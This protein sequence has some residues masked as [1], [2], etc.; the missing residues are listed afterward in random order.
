MIK[1]CTIDL[2]EEV[3]VPEAVHGL[4]SSVVVCP[5]GVM[6]NSAE[7]DGVVETSSNLGVISTESGAVSL[8]FMTRSLKNHARDNTVQRIRSCFEM[9]GAE[10]SAEGA[11]PGWTPSKD[12]K[13]LEITKSVYLGLMGKEAGVQVI[14][15]GLE[16]GLLGDIYPDWDMISFGPTITG[17]HSP[18][19]RVEIKSVERFWDL[20]LAVLEKLAR[21]YE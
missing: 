1:T 2:P 14:H 9:I 11:Y 7:F 5:N 16:C 12:P 3:M 19:E 15:A 21:S 17:A 6:R 13:L 20:L 10:V 4:L 18:D 8:L